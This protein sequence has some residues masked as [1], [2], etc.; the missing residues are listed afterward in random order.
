MYPVGSIQGSG[1]I[2]S[3]E[4]RE[5]AGR[6]ISQARDSSRIEF[7]SLLADKS[8][9]GIFQSVAKGAGSQMNNTTG[10]HRTIKNR[11]QNF[12]AH[13]SAAV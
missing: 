9:T 3:T 12:G 10:S 1:S 4:G 11:C 8:G 13:C 6:I 2:K 5:D 7:S